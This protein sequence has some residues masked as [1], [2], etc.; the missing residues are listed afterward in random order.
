MNVRALLDTTRERSDSLL[1]SGQTRA[2]RE[3]VW[4]ATYVAASESI[5]ALPLGEVVE[6][7]KENLEPEAVLD[8]DAEVRELGLRVLLRLT[9]EDHPS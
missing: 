1:S 9:T 6:L 2:S 8:C 3:P 4:T 7:L 5:D